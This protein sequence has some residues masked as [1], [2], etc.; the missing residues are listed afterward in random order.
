ML[1]WCD[2]LATFPRQSAIPRG[3]VHE[4]DIFLALFED[5]VP[6]LFNQLN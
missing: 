3:H 6:S 4:N 5:D 1:V 2:F